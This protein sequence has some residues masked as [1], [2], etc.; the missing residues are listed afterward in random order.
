MGLHNQRDSKRKCW[1]CYCI[2]FLL[3]ASCIF[4]LQRV[5]FPQL[6]IP[7]A[8]NMSTQQD[9]EGS[10]T[11]TVTL[12]NKKIFIIPFLT[13]LDSSAFRIQ[14]YLETSSWRHDFKFFA[15]QQWNTN[16]TTL[17]T[18][19]I[20]THQFATFAFNLYYVQQ[21]HNLIFFRMID[22]E[23]RTGAVM[24]FKSSSSQKCEVTFN[25]TM[26]GNF[27]NQQIIFT[28]KTL[29]NSNAQRFWVRSGALACVNT[30]DQLCM[31]VTQTCMEID[32]SSD[33]MYYD[34]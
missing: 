13:L 11:R 1:F 28:H 20:D 17:I 19:F 6:L 33:D 30:R 21:Q 5:H 12:N 3:L 10:I 22:F 27:Y 18:K 8:I 24:E 31:F 14:Q 32:E 16:I 4:F 2:V 9:E 34:D 23:E 7:V 26:T 15:K 25:S 29:T